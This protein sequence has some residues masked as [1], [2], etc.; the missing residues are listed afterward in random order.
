MAYRVPHRIPACIAVDGNGDPLILGTPLVLF[1]KR[2]WFSAPFSINVGSVTNPDGSTTATTATG[3][4]TIT[5]ADNVTVLQMYQ[6]PVYDPAFTWYV[7]QIPSAPDPVDGHIPIVS[8]FTFRPFTQ[9]AVSGVL[10]ILQASYW[11]NGTPTAGAQNLLT[12]LIS[13]NSIALVSP[14]LLTANETLLLTALE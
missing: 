10:A 5:A 6:I 3:A 8:A 9:G 12:S 13:Q 2:P 1:S 7:Y 14:S 11:N 4:V